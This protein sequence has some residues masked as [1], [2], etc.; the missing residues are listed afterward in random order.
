MNIYISL[1]PH[2]T[3]KPRPQCM[4]VGDAPFV[5]LMFLFIF[6]FSNSLK[7][8]EIENKRGARPR[9]LKT[10]NGADTNWKCGKVT[11]N[12]STKYQVKEIENLF[13]Y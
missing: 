1:S 11:V 4:S 5:V 3:S 7:V 8:Y 13:L 9:L 12:V 10:I 6:F 2:K